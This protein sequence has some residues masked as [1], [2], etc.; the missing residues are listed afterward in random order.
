[1]RNIKRYLKRSSAIKDGEN[2]KKIGK[3]LWG[4]LGWWLVIG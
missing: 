2:W 1:M 4:C 3:G